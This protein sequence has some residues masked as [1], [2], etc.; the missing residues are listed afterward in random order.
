[1]CLLLV[2][3]EL[4]FCTFGLF[5]RGEIVNLAKKVMGSDADTG[6]DCNLFCVNMDMNPDYDFLYWT[7]LEKQQ[8]FT[9]D[10]DES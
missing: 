7:D 1:M 9:E 4:Y 3:I 8:K 6:S 2:M 5:S 10:S